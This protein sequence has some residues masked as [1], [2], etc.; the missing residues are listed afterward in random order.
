M[1]QDY[2]QQQEYRAQQ[3]R[4]KYQANQQR[5]HRYEQELQ[6]LQR[7]FDKLI[8]EDVTSKKKPRTT[9]SGNH[10]PR[11]GR[12]T[13]PAAVSL[14]GGGMLHCSDEALPSNPCASNYCMH[15]KSWLASKYSVAYFIRSDSQV[16][17]GEL[18]VPIAHGLMLP[19]VTVRVDT[20]KEPRE[21][22][23]VHRLMNGET[24]VSLQLDA[25]YDEA[26]SVAVLAVEDFY[27]SQPEYTEVTGLHGYDIPCVRSHEDTW[28]EESYFRAV[29]K[30]FTGIGSTLV[31]AELKD[32]LAVACS[33]SRINTPGFAE[34][35]MPGVCALCLIRD[36]D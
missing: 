29:L 10:F 26:L 21:V 14:G 25:A 32:A 1:S 28:Y 16:N 15:R 11:V 34:R 5:Q 27:R 22:T 6:S 31:L 7:S 33:Y 8:E 30:R 2:R 4:Y 35:N 3:Y 36:F 24:A 12:S 23:V 9:A 19:S 13:K 17:E 18:L 20:S